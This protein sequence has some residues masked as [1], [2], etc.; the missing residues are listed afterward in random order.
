[1]HTKYCTH[2]QGALRNTEILKWVAV[3]GAGVK[4]VWVAC[5]LA[6]AASSAGAAAGGSQLDALSLLSSVDPSMVG[7]PAT[8]RTWGIWGTPDP[9]PDVSL[10][11]IYLTFTEGVGRGGGREKKKK[12]I[13]K[14]RLKNIQVAVNTPPP[15]VVSP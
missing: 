6:F 2:C 9:M 11:Y 8:C 12:R 5:L 15:V 14:K 4:A 1:M 7:G 3:A 13:I 10:I